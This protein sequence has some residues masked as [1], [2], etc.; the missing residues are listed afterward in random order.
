MR[1]KRTKEGSHPTPH[2]AGRPI[3]P[4]P[5]EQAS[6][7]PV[8]TLPP[9]CYR[10]GV[11]SPGLHPPPS[12]TATIRAEVLDAIGPQRRSRSEAAAVWLLGLS[13]ALILVLALALALVR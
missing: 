2:A 9:V 13:A 11:N 1:S 10:E 12:L 5:S 4:A 8:L 7:H 3:R 6:A